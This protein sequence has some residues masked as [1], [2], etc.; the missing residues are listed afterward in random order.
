MEPMEVDGAGPSNA[1]PSPRLPQEQEDPPSPSSSS[2]EQQ[3]GDEPPPACTVRVLPPT[4][5]YRPAPA[6]AQQQLQIQGSLARIAAI[7][8]R[9]EA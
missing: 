3:E 7:K 2:E 5:L 8:E 4:P 6:P 1:P 9:E